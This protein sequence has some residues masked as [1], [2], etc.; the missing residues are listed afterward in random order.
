L[1]ALISPFWFHKNLH[2]CAS[3]PYSYTSVLF[4]IQR[5]SISSVKTI[6]KIRVKR[7]FQAR[8]FRSRGCNS[9]GL[10]NY[11]KL[12]PSFG[13]VGSFSLILFLQIFSTSNTLG[14][15]IILITSGTYP[16][17]PFFLFSILPVLIL[18]EMLPL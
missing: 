1:K 4:S 3:G 8:F 2:S 17:G 7:E 16:S 18:S 14:I 15:S 13:G 10:L 9:T 6:L 5:E 11:A 12:C